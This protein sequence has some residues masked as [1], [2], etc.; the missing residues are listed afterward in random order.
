[1]KK[2]I[3][4]AKKAHFDEKTRLEAWNDFV[5]K[6]NMNREQTRKLSQMIET[7]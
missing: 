7:K 6:D 5:H 1:M 4:D 3:A 2:K